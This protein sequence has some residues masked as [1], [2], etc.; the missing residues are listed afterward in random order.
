MAF[1]SKISAKLLWE[2]LH[3][4]NRCTWTQGLA[5]SYSCIT[6][7][8]HVLDQLPTLGTKKRGVFQIPHFYDKHLLQLLSN[9]TNC[10]LI[11]N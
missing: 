9:H 1:V 2:P 11:L 5:T 10:E 6:R 3:N 8:N 4:N 7:T